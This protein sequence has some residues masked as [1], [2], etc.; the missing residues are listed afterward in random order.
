M[1]V[2]SVR[3]DT[4]EAER[5]GTSFELIGA[6]AGAARVENAASPL[7]LGVPKENCISG[8]MEAV[9]R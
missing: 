5:A 4:Q 8:C 9:A 3:F 1:P 6:K 2:T 7:R